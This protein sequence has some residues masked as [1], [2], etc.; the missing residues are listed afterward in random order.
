MWLVQMLH[1]KIKSLF[2][3]NSAGSR[4]GSCWPLQL[5]AELFQDRLLKLVFS[6]Y[7]T[8][9]VGTEAER[10][11]TAVNILYRSVVMA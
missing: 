9:R 8:G 11:P 4:E 3:K 6:H 10:F 5:K 2:C 1:L 7:L